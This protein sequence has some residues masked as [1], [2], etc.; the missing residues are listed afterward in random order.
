MNPEEFK[1]WRI[2]ENTLDLFFDGTSK[3]DP[4]AAG[5]GGVLISPGGNIEIKYSWGLGTKTNNEAEAL[6]LLKGCQLLIEKGFQSV[7]IFGDSTTIIKGLISNHG[8]KNGRLD[9]IMHRT[10]LALGNIKSI[11]I[12]HIL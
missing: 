2:T 11:K 7:N 9:S 12:Y 8:M 3:G 1:K 6:A 5:V 4:G 10:K